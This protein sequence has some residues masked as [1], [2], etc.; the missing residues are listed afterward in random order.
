MT[1]LIGAKS[2]SNDIPGPRLTEEAPSGI[3]SLGRIVLRSEQSYPDQVLEECGVRT[4]V[5]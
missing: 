1:F 4:S 3:G 5:Y 2:M